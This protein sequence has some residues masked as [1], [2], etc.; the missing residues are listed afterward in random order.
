VSIIYSPT[1]GSRID[2]CIAAAIKMAEA[3][4]ETVEFKFNGTILN[5]QFSYARHLMEEYEAQ[6]D[7]H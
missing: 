2:N 5:I 4:Q 3:A 6:R 1:P 7:E